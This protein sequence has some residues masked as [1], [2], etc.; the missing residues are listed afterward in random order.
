MSKISIGMPVYNAEQ[1][2]EKSIKS[3]LSQT[4]RN[5]ELI[6]SDNASTDSTS[7]ICKK[8]VKI[9]SRIRYFKQSKNMGPLWN[10]HFVLDQSNCEYFMWA[11]SDDRRSTSFLE[12][13]LSVIL[14]NKKAVCGMSKAKFFDIAEIKNTDQFFKNL[15]LKIRYQL[16]PDGIYPFTGSYENK[17]RKCLKKSRSWV[18]Y[19]IFRT[20]I[21]KKCVFKDEFMGIGMAWNLK[22]LQ[23]GDLVV[24]DEI[25]TEIGSGGISKK[26]IIFNSKTFNKNFLGI[27][28]PYH[29]FTSWCLKNLGIKIFIKNIDY[30]FLLNLWGGFL[31]GIDGMRILIKKI[32]RKDKK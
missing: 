16:K 5:F 18:V 32:L 2:L 22:I 24:V 13:T 28:F 12:K 14:S 17:V 4:Y 11:A 30:F 20:D 1:H 31:I 7:E 19:S 25:L 10:F 15:I 3:I 21:L 27:V 8:F 29:S 6:I 26:G 9:D 23:Y